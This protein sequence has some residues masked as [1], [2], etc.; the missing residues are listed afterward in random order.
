MYIS[1][2]HSF[3]TCVQSNI[4]IYIYIYGLGARFH[5]PSPHGIVPEIGCPSDWNMP[6]LH[7][8]PYA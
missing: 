7:M 2:T 5:G 8:D 6:A 3:V 4:N 1:T